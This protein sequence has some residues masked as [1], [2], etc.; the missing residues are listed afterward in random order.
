[1]QAKSLYSSN[2]PSYFFIKVGKNRRD[3]QI[4]SLSWM[5]ITTKHTSCD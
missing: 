2:F 1:M 4:A 5:F 3:S